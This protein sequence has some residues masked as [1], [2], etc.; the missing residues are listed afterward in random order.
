MC[1]ISVEYATA[2]AWHDFV[3]L[4]L[5]R[6]YLNF[7]AHLFFMRYYLQPELLILVKLKYAFFRRS[8]PRP[9]KMCSNSSKIFGEYCSQG[10]DFM[11]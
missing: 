3:W 11:R 1:V 5:D 2:N 8:F 10:E 6:S 4:G 9:S 7:E